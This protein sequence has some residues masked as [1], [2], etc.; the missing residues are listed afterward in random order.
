MKL[1]GDRDCW[2][3][4][5]SKR[6]SADTFLL[7]TAVFPWKKESMVSGVVVLGKSVMPRGGCVEREGGKFPHRN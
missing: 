7:K 2:G 4:R 3:L 1:R 6:T 5:Q